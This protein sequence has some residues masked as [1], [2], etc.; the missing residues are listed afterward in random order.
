MAK[1]YLMQLNEWKQKCGV[2]LDFTH[3]RIADPPSLEQ[4]EVKLSFSGEVLI[5]EKSISKK[6]GE[7]SIAKKFMT[8]KQ[9]Y[10][11]IKTIIIAR[12]IH[13]EAGAKDSSV[14][15][16]S[17]TSTPTPK[18]Q[19]VG[20]EVS[21]T[22]FLKNLTVTCDPMIVDLWAKCYI[23]DKKVAE[24]GLDCEFKFNKLATIQ[25]ATKDV[26]LV[27][28]Y[29]GGKGEGEGEGGKGAPVLTSILESLDIVKYIV[30]PNM[31]SK[32]LAK[33][34]N[35]NIKNV[36]DVRALTIDG[37]TKQM[38]ME[39]L[40]AKFLDVKLDKTNIDH[41]VWDKWPLTELQV[42]YAAQD[43]YYTLKLAIKLK[44]LQKGPD[45]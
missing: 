31:D 20:V 35:I 19:D 24:I 45:G 42:K 44:E 6:D 4:F 16:V 37:Y 17:E 10:D 26:V 3:K 40:C 28:S 34:A 1:S 8:D 13:P 21:D 9:Y 2:A 33:D 41:R 39:T 43:A 38:G 23:V 29:R 11:K 32:I 22:N 5:T 14:K 12:K 18:I 15:S 27:Y 25:V 30:D 7:Q 36:I